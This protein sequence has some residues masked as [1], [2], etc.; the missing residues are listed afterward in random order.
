M[1]KNIDPKRQRKRE[2]VQGVLLF[3]G[4]QLACMVLLAAL[5]FLPGL[6]GWCVVLFGVLAAI[7]VLPLIGALVVLRKRFQEIEGGEL[8]AA[9]EY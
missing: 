3:A 4:I 7:C 2:A 8:D 5:C 1:P 6:P 9:A